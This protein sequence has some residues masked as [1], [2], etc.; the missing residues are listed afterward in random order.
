MKIGQRVSFYIVRGRTERRLNGTV[1]AFNDLVAMVVP[2]G[3]K[4]ALEVEK[5]HIME[6]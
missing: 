5:T 1:V 3:K 6:Y 4:N 2:D